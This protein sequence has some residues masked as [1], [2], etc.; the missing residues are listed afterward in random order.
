MVAEQV[1][2]QAKYQGYIARQQ[3]EVAR[4]QHYEAM[5]LPLGLDYREVHGLSI[6]V[7]QKLNQHK[8]ETLGQAGR[9]SGVTPAAISVLLVHLK[10]SQNACNA[11]K[12]A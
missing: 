1:E 3:E 8:P 2:I 12:S 4:H 10:R 5:P 9:I 11:K 7:Q 6:E